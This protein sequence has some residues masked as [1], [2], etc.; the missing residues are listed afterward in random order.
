MIVYNYDADLEVSNTC[1]RSS[2]LSWVVPPQ[3][4]IMNFIGKVCC[5]TYTA[6]LIYR[7]FRNRV[8][9]VLRRQTDRQTHTHTGND[10]NRPHLMNNNKSVAALL[11][12]YWNVVIINTL[13]YSTA[14]NKSN[15]LTKCKQIR[16]DWLYT[17]CRNKKRRR[18]V[19]SQAPYT[20]SHKKDPR[21]F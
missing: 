18:S 2:L 17:L 1:F 19:L 7:R 21:R 16:S 12:C 20:V 15:N 13:H 5:N 9:A 11:K 3:E 6:Q 14:T 10:S 4:N 8:D